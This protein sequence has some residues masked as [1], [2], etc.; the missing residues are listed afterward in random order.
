MCR[1]KRRRNK[2]RGS[3]QGAWASRPHL[4]SF[5]LHTSGGLM[6]ATAHEV[7]MARGEPPFICDPWTAAIRRSPL[8]I[9]LQAQRVAIPQPSPTGWVSSH[10]N[11][12]PQRGAIGVESQTYFSSTPINYRPL[13]RPFRPPIFLNQIPSPMGWA[14]ELCTFGAE[15]GYQFPSPL[16]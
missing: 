10:W 12:A 4:L 3:N 5:L 8:L 15:E 14:K 7:T 2:S 11:H 1:W 6:S 9:P 16:G 13:S